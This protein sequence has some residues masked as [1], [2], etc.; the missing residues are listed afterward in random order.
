[1]QNFWLSDNMLQ[2]VSI[3]LKAVSDFRYL[4]HGKENEAVCNTIFS[5]SVL[6]F[7]YPFTLLAEDS[8]Y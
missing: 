2:G 4:S 1:M 6:P 7:L 5:N 3:N 8:R